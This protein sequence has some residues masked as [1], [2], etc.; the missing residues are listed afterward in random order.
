MELFERV[1]VLLAALAP[2]SLTAALLLAL[3][4]GSLGG[5]LGL[6]LAMG[7]FAAFGSIVGWI[8]EPLVALFHVPLPAA[9]EEAFLGAAL[10]EELAKLAV[11]VLR[12]IRI[13]RHSRSSA[14]HSP[15]TAGS[16]SS[17]HSASCRS[18]LR[19]SGVR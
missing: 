11:L 3:S 10:P 13:V 17:W 19:P 8:E 2:A 7:P 15:S 16:P 5:V 6:A 1:L 9:F 18:P 12:I 4:A 14:L